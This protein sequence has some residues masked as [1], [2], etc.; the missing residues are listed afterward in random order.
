MDEYL[1]AGKKAD[2]YTDR[3][4]K[5]GIVRKAEKKGVR[6]A[7]EHFIAAYTITR[8]LGSPRLT[9]T[10][11]VLQELLISPITGRLAGST[12]E[13]IARDT[14]IDYYHN[15]LGIEEAVK[16][17]GEDVSLYELVR[18]LAKEGRFRY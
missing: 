17:S 10:L 1:D 15:Q 14:E 9:W 3:M 11:G 6:N 8:E 12:K 18:R 13:E 4:I 16:H 7:L 2:E 5:E